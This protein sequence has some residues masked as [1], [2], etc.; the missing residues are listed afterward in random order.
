MPDIVLVQPPIREF[1]LTRKRTVPYGLA[2]IAAACSQQGFTVEILDALARDKSKALPY[3]DHF[4]HLIPHYGRQDLS[5]F[6]LFHRFRHFGYSHEHLG[7]QVRDLDPRVVGISSLFTAYADQALATAEAVRRFCP[8]AVIVMGGHHPT[9]FP[10]QTLDHP[11][12]DFVLRGEGEA[13]LPMLCRHLTG[14]A[15]D[16]Q[17]LKAVPGIAFRTSSGIFAAPPAW[18]RDLSGLPLPDLEKTD[19]EYCFRNGRAAIT[20]VASRGCPFPCTYCSV[21]S[22]SSHGRFRQR[23]VA[24]VLRE[25]RAQADKSDVGFI[26]FEDENLTLKKDWVLTLLS[27]IRDIFR[28]GQVELRAMNGLYPPSLD[29]DILQAM[30]DSGFRTLN[31]SVGSFSR[32]QL[33]RFRRPD[34]TADHDRVIETAAKLGLDCVSYIIAGAPGQTAATTLD[35]LLA[36]A[37]RRTLAGLSVF[38]PAPGSMDYRRCQR[39]GMLPDRFSLMRATALPLDHTTPRLAAVT[40]MR[41]ARMLN[42]MKSEIDTRGRLPEPRRFTPGAAV[43]D[44]RDRT[45]ASRRLLQWFLADGVIRGLDPSGTVYPHHQ[46]ARVAGKFLLGLK[47]GRMRGVTGGP[48]RLDADACA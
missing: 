4:K 12:V 33:S 16:D 25:I 43:A 27:G 14:Q 18:V 21:S 22:S 28:Q 48:I 3:P 5:R 15:R 19:R 1:Y 32:D 31:L 46:D 26:D 39:D 9:L 20:V 23:P 47:K 6:A 30:K 38:Y 42:F 2:S 34:V 17:R 11:A 7:T 44:P 45:A 36:L 29:P 35:D 8:N 10:E 24:D 37:R 41:L 40:L 13:G